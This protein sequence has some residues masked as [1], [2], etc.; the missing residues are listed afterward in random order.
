M[1]KII[2]N[3]EREVVEQSAVILAT[4]TLIE[5]KLKEIKELNMQIDKA[6][7]ELDDLQTTLDKSILKLR[8]KW[9]VTIKE[10]S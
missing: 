10:E 4:S 8:E 6:W 1:V 3:V 7:D 2:E 9:N 5:T